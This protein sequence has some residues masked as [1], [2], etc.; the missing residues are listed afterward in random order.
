LQRAGQQLRLSSD[1][2]HWVVYDQPS[3]ATC[4]EP[5]SGPPDA[6][7]LEPSVLAPGAT[8]QKHFLI[9]WSTP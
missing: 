7:N 9:E 3:F 8:L 6:F 1:C 2:T 4:V 5:Q